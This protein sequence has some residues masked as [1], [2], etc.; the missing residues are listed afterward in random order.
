MSENE[1]EI[2][3]ESLK[4]LEWEPQGTPVIGYPGTHTERANAGGRPTDYKPEYDEQA[5]KLCK[6]GATDK[7]LADFF[8][9]SETTI[10]NWKIAYPSFFES[11]TRGK[12]LPDD[13]VEE[14]LFN[15]AIGYEYEE[16][17]VSTPGEGGSEKSG[18]K[19]TYKKKAL[20]DFRAQRFWLMNRRPEKWREKQEIETN[21]KHEIKGGDALKSIMAE[22]NES[23]TNNIS[24]TD[25]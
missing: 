6:L 18:Y 20:G 14:A 15:T 2:P 13:K 7:V 5:E 8:N 9:V 19:T 10:N 16:E 22:I 25:S 21:N 11:I 12:V 23:I 3:L 4:N 17:S 24:T 1:N